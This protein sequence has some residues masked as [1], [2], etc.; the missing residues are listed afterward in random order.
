[1]NSRLQIA[2]VREKEATQV[3]PNGRAY[4]HTLL[5]G[6]GL[7]RKQVTKKGNSVLKIEAAEGRWSLFRAC[8]GIN[9]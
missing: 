4:R 9:V 6:E 8:P 1:M 3:A 2:A 5:Q 7:G